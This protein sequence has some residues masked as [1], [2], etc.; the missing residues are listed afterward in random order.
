MKKS[1]KAIEN[2]PP[3][4]FVTINEPSTNE[5]DNNSLRKMTLN[6]ISDQKIL[7]DIA[8]NGENPDVCRDAVIKY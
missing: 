4:K 1:L 8:K 7:A 2:P 6:R 5:G 3:K